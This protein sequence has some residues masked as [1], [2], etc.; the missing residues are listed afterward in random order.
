VAPS[1][2]PSSLVPF[3]TSVEVLQILGKKK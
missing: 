2:E 1:S 3:S